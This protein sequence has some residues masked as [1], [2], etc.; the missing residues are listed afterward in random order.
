MNQGVLC[1]CNSCNITG[2]LLQKH[3]QIHTGPHSRTL[4]QVQRITSEV[5]HLSTGS[6]YCY[7][8]ASRQHTTNCCQGWWA[9]TAVLCDGN[10]NT[11][12]TVCSHTDISSQPKHHSNS[13]TVST[14][15]YVLWG[16]RPGRYECCS[17]GRSITNKGQTVLK[18]AAVRQST[19]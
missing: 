7:C 4:R 17:A 3:A 11:R 13:S 14:A 19:S 18:C 16:V 8:Q 12:H 2:Y 15:M 6:Y 5:C 1:A 9:N 10:T